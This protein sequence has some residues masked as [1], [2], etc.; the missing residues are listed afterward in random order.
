MFIEKLTEIKDY[1]EVLCTLKNLSV[2]LLFLN[3]F[4]EAQEVYFYLIKRE[5]LSIKFQ[6]ISI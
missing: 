5:L 3:H 4:K 1:S 2:P 6:K